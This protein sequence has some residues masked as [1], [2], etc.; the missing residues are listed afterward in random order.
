MQILYIATAQTE[1]KKKK[2]STAHKRD[3]NTN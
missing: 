3:K 1:E 2:K